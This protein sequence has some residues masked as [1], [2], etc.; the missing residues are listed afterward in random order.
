MPAVVRIPPRRNACRLR[1]AWRAGLVG[2][3]LATASGAALSAPVRSVAPL[4][5][6]ASPATAGDGTLQLRFNV[7]L[8]AQLG[9]VAQ[10]AD[11][12]ALDGD[13]LSVNLIAHDTARFAIGGASVAAWHGGEFVATRGFRLVDAHGATR[14]DLAS[15][16][17]RPRAGSTLIDFVGA[18]GRVAL[19]ADAV[20]AVLPD[21]GA[22]LRIDAMDIRLPDGPTIADAQARLTA[23]LP[24]APRASSCAVPNWPG[25]GGGAYVADL[26]LDGIA[27]QTMRCGEPGCSG[28]ACTCDGPGGS[29]AAV[30]FAPSAQLSNGT[31]D[32]DGLPCTAA[33]PCSADLP[34]NARF[35]PDRPPYGNDQHPLLVWNLYRLDA[36][37]RIAQ[38]GRSGV[39]HAFVA[40]NLGCDCADSQV[41]GRGCSDVYSTNNNDNNNALGPRSEVV[42]AT[43]TWGRCGAL[44]DD[45]VLVPNPDLGGCDGASD[46]TGNTRWSHRLI[47]RE[48]QIDAAAHPGSRWLF[49]AWYL[50]RDDVNIDNS[51]GFIEIT[52][53]WNAAWTAVPT[54]GTT[55][56][57]GAA[58]DAWADPADPLVRVDTVDDT[59]G[60]LRLATRVRALG[61]GRWRYDYAL[62]NFTYAQAQTA[63]TEPN[64]RVLSSA[65]VAGFAVPL[66][67][68]VVATSPEFDDGD[69]DAGNDWPA[70]RDATTAR[71]LAAGGRSLDWGTL[72]RYSLVADAAPVDG[73]ASALLAASAGAP[74]LAFTSLVPGPR[75]TD[76]L[77][78]DGFE[79]S[80]AAPQHYT[81]TFFN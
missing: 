3:A 2:F 64:L 14:V 8:L 54:S 32:N 26:L 62:M 6:A 58:L 51:M 12:R 56:R 71:W 4:W 30:V 45:A 10:S 27:V 70:A 68:G 76:R 55:F 52:P 60:R 7:D 44:D 81:D 49:E 67:D 18:D 57:R 13:T 65:G 75:D 63:G 37:G 38:I 9:L 17:V 69:L 15:L 16:R 29:D 74:A 33:D 42:P 48:S 46:A 40:L 21:D 41:L 5:L 66:A 80:L 24:A 78:G 31:D 25:S 34:W 50:V 53:S 1:R 73:T 59:R 23:T 43:A 20:M 79:P 28:A 22:T 35:S 77:F 61:G 39:K 11:G 36:D 72:M 47:A 19:T